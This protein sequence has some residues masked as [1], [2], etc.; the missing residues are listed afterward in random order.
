MKVGRAHL[1]ARRQQ[2]RAR[3]R[4]RARRPGGDHR[5]RARRRHLPQLRGARVPG[6]RRP[7]ARRRAARRGARARRALPRGHHLVARRLLRPQRRA[8]SRRRRHGHHERRPLLGPRARRPHR[9]RCAAPACSTARWRPARS[10]RS[11]ACS[12]CARGCICVVS[13]RTPWPGPAEI[14]LD[15]NMDAAIDVATDAM[16]ACSMRTDLADSRLA[17]AARA[18]LG[19]GPRLHQ[20]QD[21]AGSRSAREPSPRACR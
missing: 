15:R 7:R 10:S 3:A 18:V 1:P 20:G 9:G 6:G 21:V 2:R 5:R 11:R 12:A 8:A 14:D 16:R 13:D 17:R 19:R 4:P